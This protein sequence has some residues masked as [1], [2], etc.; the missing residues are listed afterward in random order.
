MSYANTETWF[1]EDDRWGR[2]TSC[3]KHIG[4]VAALIEMYNLAQKRLRHYYN[5]ATDLKQVQAEWRKYNWPRGSQGTGSCPIHEHLAEV[6]KNFDCTTYSGFPLEEELRR[7]FD[8]I[9]ATLDVL[10]R[11]RA[12]VDYLKSKNGLPASFH[13]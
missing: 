13:I 7:M 6:P 5:R 4:D 11:C 2:R 10:T 3:V 9:F 12:K 8:E 1:D